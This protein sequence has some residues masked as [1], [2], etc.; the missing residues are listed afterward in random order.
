LKIDEDEA[1]REKKVFDYLKPIFDEAK[2]K[3]S[4]E[5]AKNN[6]ASVKY[7]RKLM[8]P[9]AIDIKDDVKLA[10]LKQLAKERGDFAHRQRLIRRVLGPEDAKNTVK[11]CLEVCDDIRNKAN[12]KFV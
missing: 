8:I 12:A 1:A 10:S 11:D 2:D 4:K 6:G 3:F 9:V 5:V 7:L